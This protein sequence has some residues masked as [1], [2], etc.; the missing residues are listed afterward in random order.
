MSF[1]PAPVSEPFTKADLVRDFAAVRAWGTEFWD[2]VPPD[3]FF[4]PLREG[5]WSP[6]DHARHLIKSNRAVLLGLEIPRFILLLR[7]G[8]TNRASRSYTGL[9]SNYYEAL[10][11]GLRAGKFAPSELPVEKHTDAERARILKNWS[12]TV[13][14][15]ET[16]T[17]K[18]S[19]RALNKLRMPHPGLGML[20]VREMLFFTLYHNTHHVNGVSGKLST[21]A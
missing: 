5:G 12:E 15:L 7:F 18:W 4:K 2:S 17:P 6:A 13:T 14:K 21:A 3:R 20:T 10:D 19:D 9:R 16:V 1:R 11:S 8:F